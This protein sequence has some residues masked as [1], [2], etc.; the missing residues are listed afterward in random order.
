MPC[1]YV[2]HATRWGL[3]EASYCGYA[4][5]DRSVRE[6]VTLM[7]LPL[8]AL[9]SPFFLATAHLGGKLPIAAVFDLMVNFGACYGRAVFFDNLMILP[10]CSCLIG[11]YLKGFMSMINHIDF[12]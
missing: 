11:I 12:I 6:T 5:N 10:P 4:R 9:L 2:R 7:P 3:F 8:K 1:K